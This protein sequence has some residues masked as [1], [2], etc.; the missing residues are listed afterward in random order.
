[1]Y[2]WQYVGRKVSSETIEIEY[3]LKKK[4]KASYVLY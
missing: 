2:I 4:V 3:L 1:M